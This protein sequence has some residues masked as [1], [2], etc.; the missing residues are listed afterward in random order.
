[1]AESAPAHRIVRFGVFAVDLRAGE[2]HRQ[3]LKIKLQ[4]KPFQ[5]LALLLEHPGG[6][7]TREELQQRLWPGDTFVDFDHSLNIAVAKLRE[8]LGDS[9]D[10]PRYVETLP[11]RGY[12]FIAPVETPGQVVSEPRARLRLVWVG[13]LAVVALVVV[14][15][16]AWFV[17]LQPAPALTES[18]HI[19]LADWVNH[20]GDPIFEGTLQQGLAVKLE[21]SPFLSIV[22]DQQVR[23]TLRLM[24]RSPDEPITAEVGQEICQREGVKAMIVGEMAPLGDH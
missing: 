7:V 19:L 2:L 22:S 20:T 6:V 13:A 21:E 4:E 14:L 18:D 23:E 5:V 11:R 17:F 10:I 24:K 8:A 1:M 12:R 16:A 15:V 9:A 3:G